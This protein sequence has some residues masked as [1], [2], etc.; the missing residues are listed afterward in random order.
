MEWRGPFAVRTQR[1]DADP[2]RADTPIMEVPV[3]AVP[4]HGAFAVPALED[5]SPYN[6]EFGWAPDLRTSTTEVP[7]AQ[8][9]QAIPL[10]DMRPGD[11]Q[12]PEEYWRK[13]DRD[14]AQRHSVEHQDADGW[15]ERK[16]ISPGD[17]R[18]EYN[19]RLHP[20]EEPRP[21][22]RMAPTTYLF[23]RPFA[24]DTARTLNGV[25]FSMADHRRDYEILGMAPVSSRRNTYRQDPMPWDI[26]IVDLPPQQDPATPQARLRGIDLP[27]PSRAWRLD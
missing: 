27:A 5:G 9:L 6:D 25:H 24:Q 1:T 13:R 16:G 2:M 17:K 18:W 12:P 15:Q 8:R 26:D 21:T 20:P 14:D 10:Y 7:S 3:Y 11:D 22:T 23:T 4:Q 19:P